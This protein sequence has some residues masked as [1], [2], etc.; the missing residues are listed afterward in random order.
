MRDEIDGVRAHR[1]RRSQHRYATLSV[2][3]HQSGAQASGV[4]PVTKIA[5]ASPSVA[6]SKPSSRSSA[7]PCT[8]M[9]SAISFTPKV[10]LSADSARSPICVNTDKTTPAAA[11]TA[12]LWEPAA[13]ANSTDTNAAQ[14][15]PAMAPAHVF[16][17]DTDG[18]SFGPPAY[19]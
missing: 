6:N 17:G 13:N 7:P 5:P 18:A 12:T 1:S 3:S 11:T 9:R 8:G 10:R 19:E 14:A 2:N 4:R 16:F 15:R